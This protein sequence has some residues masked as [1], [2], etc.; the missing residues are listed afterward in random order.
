MQ[1]VPLLSFTDDVARTSLAVLLNCSAKVA[2]ASGKLALCCSTLQS[3]IMPALQGVL[4]A[5]ANPAGSDCSPRGYT[6][7]ALQPARHVSMP[8]GQGLDI[9][10][11]TAADIAEQPSLIPKACS[12][13][14]LL[15]LLPASS[16]ASSAGA[17]LLPSAASPLSAAARQLEVARD[18]RLRLKGLQFSA[19]S[20]AAAEG[21]PLGELLGDG[22]LEGQPEL[23]AD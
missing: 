6:S 19:L 18:S 9:W 14:S 15:L 3:H 7:A 4:Q 23:E 21:E 1:S 11:G 12:R 5:P 22:C 8:G 20:A 16:P 2:S 10:L 13:A 17:M